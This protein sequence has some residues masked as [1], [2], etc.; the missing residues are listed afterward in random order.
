MERHWKWVLIIGILALVADAAV[1]DTATL[2]QYRYDYGLF[3]G[4][5]EL[6][7][8]VIRTDIQ[9]KEGSV[10]QPQHE[11]H[12]IRSSVIFGL[13]KVANHQHLTQPRKFMVLGFNREFLRLLL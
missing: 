1:N 9:G 3:S 12:L 10:F 7:T 4:S 2:R 8:E 5:L 13:T 6:A 11:P